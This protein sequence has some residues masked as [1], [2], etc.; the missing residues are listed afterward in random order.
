MKKLL[1][2]LMVCF[3]N[4]VFAQSVKISPDVIGGDI[5]DCPVGTCPMATISIDVFNFHKP[6]TNCT[7]GFGFCLRLSCGIT[8]VNCYFKGSVA[9]DKVTAY[10]KMTSTVAELHVPV[11]LKTAKGFEK[12][13]MST[14]EVEDKSLSF[15]TST[16]IE[17][18]VKG[19]TYPVTVVG[20][21]YVI[22]LNL[23]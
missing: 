14:F 10:A 16:G 23:Y 1:F 20:D 3:A 12:T 15:K 8:C 13:D 22:K 7:S 17:K 6:R 5:P 2:I 21:E 19:G 9:G 11:G 18:L 4:S